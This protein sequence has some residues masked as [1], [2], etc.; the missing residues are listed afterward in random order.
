M[1]KPDTDAAAQ[2]LA[3]NARVLERR[4]FERLFRA[5]SGAAVRDAVT[6][7]HNSDGGFGHGL[8]PDLRDPASQASA[9]EIALSTLDECDAW[10]DGLAGGACDWLQAN[11]PV[12]GGAAFVLPTVTR[13]PH[14]PWWVPEP[15]GPP[16]LIQ[17]GQ[18]SATTAAG[19]S[20]GRPGHRLRNWTAGAS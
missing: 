10:D 5:G 6:A 2:F 4:R 9:I 14:A 7:Y 1:S 11:A 13:W 18:A 19:R 20:T 16:S 15:G 17:T 8:E 3:A 12:E